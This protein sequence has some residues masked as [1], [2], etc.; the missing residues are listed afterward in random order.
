MQYGTFYDVRHIYSF[1]LCSSHI[2]CGTSS[3][4]IVLKRFAIIYGRPLYYREEEIR[5]KSDV[6]ELGEEGCGCD[7]I[8]DFFGNVINECIPILK[9]YLRIKV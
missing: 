5:H 2:C 8:S 1:K 9:V 6:F 4:F 7:R 3:I